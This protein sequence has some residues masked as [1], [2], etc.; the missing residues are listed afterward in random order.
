MLV[1]KSSL[2]K[3]SART[4]RSGWLAS[5]SI[6]A[7]AE[8]VAEPSIVGDTVA[9]GSA[10]D[11]LVGEDAHVAAANADAGS[12]AQDTAPVA[13]GGACVVVDAGRG[14][15]TE[16][17]DLA[18]VAAMGAFV[19]AFV[20]AV[21][22]WGLPIDREQV[23]AWTLGLVVA[24]SLATGHRFNAARAVRDWSVLAVLLVAYDYSSGGADW[25]GMPLQIDA[26]II[27][28]RALFPGDVPTVELQA[29]LGPF[30]GQRWWEAALAI[31]YVTHFFVPYAVTAYLWLRDRSRWRAWLTQFT[32]VTS[33]GLAGFVLLPTMP[34][35]LAS[36]HGHLDEVQGV[37]TRGWRL[38]NLDIAEA[39]IDKGHATVNL[40]AAFPSL[41]AAYPA[42]TAAFFWPRLSRPGRVAL[43]AYPLA[44][45]LT[46]VISGDH[47]VIDVIGGWAVVGAVV[48]AWRRLSSRPAVT[49]WLAV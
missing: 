28:D 36:L 4:V 44:M 42:L 1:P 9:S 26:P 23:L 6:D 29:R 15:R 38:L 46:L 37:A 33:A 19:A 11:T 24:V 43:V 21:G 22:R 35:W 48:A 17:G 12:A 41:H 5:L 31:T 7:N 20:F 32:A 34:P 30:H 16:V 13:V 49:R 40:V 47:Y 10:A 18:L 27:I 45:A 14:R 2:A 8:Y 3:Q 39:L 25:F